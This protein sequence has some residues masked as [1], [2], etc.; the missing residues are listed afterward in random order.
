MKVTFSLVSVIAAQSMVVCSA[1]ALAVGYPQPKSKDLAKPFTGKPVPA[2]WLGTWQFA[3]G[4]GE[5]VVWHIYPRASPACRSIT[6]GRI[7][8]WT[9]RPPGWTADTAGAI[10]IRQGTVVLRMTYTPNRNSVSC[11]KDDAYGYRHTQRRLYLLKRS[12]RHCFW[13]SSESF[14]IELRRST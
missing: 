9:S 13:E 6:A 7:S 5:V 12:N 2:S 8:C 14:P 10:G 11:F 1:W 4:P 3:L